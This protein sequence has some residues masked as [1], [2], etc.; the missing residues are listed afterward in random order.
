MANNQMGEVEDYL[1]RVDCPI[2]V[3]LPIQVTIKK[4]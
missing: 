3:C 1:I 2:D 4:E